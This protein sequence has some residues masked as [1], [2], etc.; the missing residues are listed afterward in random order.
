MTA[1]VRPSGLSETS[2]M[3]GGAAPRTADRFG[4]TAA[5]KA[6][7]GR[8]K[9]L[10]VAIRRPSALKLGVKTVS[11]WPGS[12]FTI[13]AAAR[14]DEGEEAVVAADDEQPPRGT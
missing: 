2:P 12:R 7:D 4:P 1:S 5:H 11:R 3:A 6:D 9:P 13:A 8:P 10:A 14:V